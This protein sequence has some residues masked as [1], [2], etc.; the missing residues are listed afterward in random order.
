[1]VTNAYA[2][3]VNGVTR[4]LETCVAGLLA[5]GHEVRIFA[6]DSAGVQNDPSYVVRV[7]ALPRNDSAAPIP[8]IGDWFTRLVTQDFRPDVIHSHA[9]FLLGEHA[10]DLRRRFAAPVV[11]T[12]HTMY[13]EHAHHLRLPV[14]WLPAASVAAD[15][16]AVRYANRCDLV[17]APSRGVA[18][19]LRKNRVITPTRVL[20]TGINPAA[21]RGDRARAR[22]AL[23]FTPDDFVLGH[24]GRLSV[25]K[26]LEALAGAVRDYLARDA[27]AK[28]LVVGDGRERDALL[29]A[30]PPNRVVYTG[31]LQDQPLA[32]AYAAMDVFVF[33][34]QSETQGLI[35]AEALLS[36]VPVVAVSAT[37]VDDVVQHGLNGLLV[38]VPEK[39]PSALV[40]LRAQPLDR[41]RLPWS[42]GAF[43]LGT[44]LRQLVQAYNDVRVSAHGLRK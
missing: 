9:P 20:P 30:L 24:V 25:E 26:N 36:Y 41:G 23:G 14:D 19:R 8:I 17:L 11:F 32:N 3:Y 16:I 15:K 12:W 6:P 39:L 31:T 43:V 33:A 7:P 13:G 22:A 38:D 2:P 42:A 27:S 37:G 34:S 1:M 40:Q 18:A 4:S 10:L 21:F 44:T 35:L 5:F 28:F 29:A